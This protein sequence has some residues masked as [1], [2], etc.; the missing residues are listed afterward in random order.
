MYLLDIVKSRVLSVGWGLMLITIIAKFDR[1]INVGGLF[2]CADV[3]F[4]RI[5]ASQIW[6]L[7]EGD[8]L[9]VLDF[10]EKLL[11][12]GVYLCLSFLIEHI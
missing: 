6:H 5:V 12:L 9:L 7:P 3:W 4:G 1:F 2:N 11:L 10:S 8:Y